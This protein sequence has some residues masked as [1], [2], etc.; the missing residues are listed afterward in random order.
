MSIQ[1][2]F[3]AAAPLQVF[4][5]RSDFFINAGEKHPE[6]ERYMQR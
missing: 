5:R 3:L 4:Y 6:K 2:S 1:F